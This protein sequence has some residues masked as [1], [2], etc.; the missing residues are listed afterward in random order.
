M[1]NMTLHLEGAQSGYFSCAKE[2]ED[3]G[4]FN[5]AIRLYYIYR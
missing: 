2:K 1:Q 3:E 5:E 4:D